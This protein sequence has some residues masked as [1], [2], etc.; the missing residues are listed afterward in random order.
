[1]KGLFNKLKKARY[2]VIAAFATVLVGA[3]GYIANNAQA[4]SAC[5]KTNI[6]YCGIGG[7][8]NSLKAAYNTS[9]DTAGHTD[10]RRVMQ[11]GGFTDANIASATSANVKLGTVNRSGVITV[12]GKTVGTGAVVTT[13]YGKAGRQQVLP[14]VYVRSSAENQLATEQVLVLFDRDGKAVAS[15][16]VR[17]GNVLK[18][19][20]VI[21]KKPSLVCTNL[22][23][24]PTGK[25]REYKFT[26]TANSKDTSITSYVFYFG[27]GTY[28]TVMSSSSSASVTHTYGRNSTTYAGKVYVNGQGFANVTSTACQEKVTTPTPPKPE[29]KTPKVDVTKTVTD[30][31]V[32]QAVVG[33]DTEY[34]YELIVKNTG[35]VDLKDVVVTDTP[36]AGVTLN[37]NQEVGT[38][39]NNVW[40]T[41]IPTLAVGQSK[42]FTLKAKVPTYKAGL[43][44]NTVCVDTPTIPGG[45]DDCDEAKVEVPEPGKVKVCE[46]ETKN[47]IEVPEADKNKPGY[48]DVDSELCKEKPVTPVAELPSTG[49]TETIMATVGLGTLA[50]AGYFWQGSRRK[51]VSSLLNR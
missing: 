45:P 14:G 29:V 50:G 15:L 28:R 39:T 8:V 46:V 35:E 3:A 25:A 40:K 37:A 26:A 32:K 12:G 9:R 44:N 19:T 1:M 49:P 36:E 33:V 2:L 22:D 21:P 42:T 23:I 51:M 27:D 6:I 4:V 20:P 10:I 17:C 18:F 41:T 16:I 38:V 24:A 43:L 30:K 13:R 47:I 11:W 7:D 48:A 5:D 31:R 34:T